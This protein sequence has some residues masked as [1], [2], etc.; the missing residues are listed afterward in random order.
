MHIPYTY[1]HCSVATRVADVI[2]PRGESRERER[3]FCM[4]FQI[5]EMDHLGL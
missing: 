2:G 1:W 4:K 3:F 5:W